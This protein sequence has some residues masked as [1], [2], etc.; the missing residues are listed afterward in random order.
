MTTQKPPGFRGRINPAY[1]ATWSI[2][3]AT[4]IFTRLRYGVSPTT[5]APTGTNLN[6]YP[7]K[8]GGSRAYGRITG[9]KCPLRHPFETFAASLQDFPDATGVVDGDTLT[10]N[11][12]LQEIVF[13]VEKDAAGGVLPGHV[14]WPVTTGDT[15][16][17]VFE[18][19]WDQLMALAPALDFEARYV[20]ILGVD[21]VSALFFSHRSHPG[22]YGRGALWASTVAAIVVNGWGAENTDA[23][24]RNS[25]GRIW[26]PIRWGLSRAWAS[27]E[28]PQPPA[29][30]GPQ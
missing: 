15:A 23:G 22:M 26:F 28:L 18:S 6:S 21:A 25:Y 29:E 1:G 30:G 5:I 24:G 16:A 27:A 20:G 13:E 4:G 8:G 3:S 19:W 12:G 14:A 9:R 2:H 11:D 10:I 17:M 7:L